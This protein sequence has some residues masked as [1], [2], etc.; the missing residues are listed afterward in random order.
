MKKHLLLFLVLYGCLSLHAQD[1]H[2]F[3]EDIQK[4]ASIQ[5]PTNQD[6][7]VFT[8]SSS[9]RF[10]KD[11][12]SDCSQFYTINTGFG[13]SE[14][15]DLLYF[16]EETVLRFQP[17]TIFLYEG[18]ND[19]VAGKSP[20]EIIATTKKVMDR[21]QEA[22]PNATIYLISAKPSP[23]RWAFKKQYRKLNKKFKAYSNRHKMIYYIDVW[24]PML[25]AQ[26]RP[27]ASI[28]VEDSL[29]INR[30]GYLIWKD[31]ICNKIYNQ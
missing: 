2:R 20:K 15:S 18:D 9:I 28:F 26:K 12:E 11:L 25:D 1:P 21:I 31:Q 14:M 29:H 19:I 24:N 3:D 7:A 30:K 27:K 10:W 16:I 22:L 5:V 17:K 23:S 6:I 4:F 8:G 13:G